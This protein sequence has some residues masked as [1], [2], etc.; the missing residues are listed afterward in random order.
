MSDTSYSITLTNTARGLNE[1]IQCGDRQFIIQAAKEKG[2]ELEYS[3]R[4]SACSSCAAKL[5]S[6]KVDQ[7]KQ[8]FLDD[9]QVQAGWVI[10]CA[11]IPLSDCAVEVEQ[12]DAL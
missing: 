6:G 10:L 1:T 3:C 11:A 2:V 4:A 5:V 12:E 8:S 7:S 9:E